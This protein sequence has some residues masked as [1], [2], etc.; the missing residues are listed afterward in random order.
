[1][2]ACQ[3]FFLPLLVVVN[4]AVYGGRSNS[5]N[6]SGYWYVSTNVTALGLNVNN[7]SISQNILLALL[8]KRKEKRLIQL[9]Q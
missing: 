5:S 2:Y 9:L 6:S 4:L 7:I 1:M 8:Q 3:L